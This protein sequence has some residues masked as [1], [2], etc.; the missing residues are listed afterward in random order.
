[1]IRFHVSYV[2]LAIISI[3]AMHRISFAE[4]TAPPVP[5]Q[6]KSLVE[7]GNVEIEFYDPSTVKTKYPGHA[8]FYIDVRNQFRYDYQVIVRQKRHHVRIRPV[9]QRT[10][11]KLKNT[12]KLPESYDTPA[13]WETDLMLHELDHVAVSS[14]P[15][16]RML[17]ERVFAAATVIEHPIGP[18]SELDAATIQ[19]I[20]DEEFAKRRDAVIEVVKKNNQMMDEVSVHGAREIP[21]RDEFF[22][23]LY[24]KSR[25]DDL[26]FPYLGDVL[27][28]LKTAKYEKVKLLHHRG[29]LAE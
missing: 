3:G 11:W 7:T 17:M 26:G 14:D 12:V 24:S 19:K 15:R 13:V 25:L 8:S 27:G 9:I 16:V 2:T 10:T 29:M 18:P 22:R 20:I 6:L 28:L 5:A 1:M 23:K 4:D 21:D